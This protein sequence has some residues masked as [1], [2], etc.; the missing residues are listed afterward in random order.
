MSNDY[1]L[2]VDEC[3]RAGGPTDKCCRIYKKAAKRGADISQREYW[4]AVREGTTRH[5]YRNKDG[6]PQPKTGGKRV[7]EV[8]VGIV[9]YAHQIEEPIVTEGEA[10]P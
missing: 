7:S 5:R 6:K 8:A 10:K 9:A 2:V 1:R 4:M 3:T